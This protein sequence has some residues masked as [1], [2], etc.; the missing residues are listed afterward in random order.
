VKA[1]YLNKESDLPRHGFRTKLNLLSIH[2]MLKYKSLQPLQ[3][4]NWKCNIERIFGRWIQIIGKS[5]RC[6]AKASGIL[7]K[8]WC[9]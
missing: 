9:C 1:C 3:W 4:K 6:F 2:G 8:V 7:Q 5:I